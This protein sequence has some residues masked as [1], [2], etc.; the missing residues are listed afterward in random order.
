MVFYKVEEAAKYLGI[1]PLSMK[2][3]AG[4]GRISAQK[5]EKEWV[6]S[7]GV[8]KKYRKEH[9]PRGCSKLTKKEWAR[10]FDLRYGK[11][12]YDRLL[13]FFELPCITYKRIAGYFGVEPE[14][15]R[16]WHDRL[17]PEKVKTGHE[18]R[19]VC[20]VSK[21]RSRILSQEP[22][23]SFYRR[24]ASYFD[25]ADIELINRKGMPYFRKRAASV[26]NKKILLLRA[27]KKRE[28]RNLYS[29]YRPLED[30]D[31]VYYSLN[32]GSFLLV[33]E[34]NLPQK[35]TLYTDSESSKYYKFKNNFNALLEALN[36]F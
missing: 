11:D 32:N 25:P 28:S 34:G 24:A 8:L 1:S 7:E 9:L 5:R 26:N 2:K 22:M 23:K 20:A 13:R 17:F 36:S 15:V 31:F 29:I 6:F 19:H 35:R 18:R 33:P 30:S 3:Y 27:A 14:L 21:E 16:Q 10:N 12:A 4:T